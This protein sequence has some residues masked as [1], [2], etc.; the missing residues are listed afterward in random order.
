MSH[1][2]KVKVLVVDDDAAHAEATAESLERAGFSMSTVTSG[3]EGVR[4]IEAEPFDIVV[5]DLVMRDLSGLDLLRKA[6]ARWP[7]IEVIVMTGY[8][9]YETAVEALDGG[10]YDYLDK[11][12]NLQIL[13]AKLKKA[14]EKQ[15]LVRDNLE[16]RRQIDKRFGFQGIVGNTQRMRKVFDVLQQVSP[17]NAT[18]LILGESGT[19]KELVARAIHQ[20]SP[21]RGNHFVPL[22]C[23]ALSESILE[24]EL[25][26]HVK[27][28][29]TGATYDRKG[30]FEYA[31]QGTL[32]LDEIGDMPL[33]IQVKLLRVI[34]YGEIFRVGSNEPIKVDVRLVCAT[35]QSL[36]G[37][38]RD[39]R[40]REDLYFRL[41]VVTVELP[42][43]RERLDDLPLLVDTFIK[44]LSATHKK[45]I[46]RI[47][48][49]AMQL[50]YKYPWPGNVRELR[51]AIESMIV[52]TKDDVLD[53]DD[54]P[55][56]ITTPRATG[57]S[58]PGEAGET[59]VHLETAEKEL[60]RQAL[61]IS[62]GNREKA[63]QLLGI[64]ERTL[65]RKIKRFELG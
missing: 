6:K 4:A 38:I 17:S 63:A 13:R 53:G 41:K 46:S 49:E 27:G 43:L 7:D 55:N 1:P 14:V 19:G 11:P 29:F 61:A 22:N 58:R 16:L 39:G 64:G 3:N 28:A 40:F 26:G 33:P 32:F 5:T 8:P 12:V 9:S 42:P 44:E 30:R 65:Y 60:I 31:H 59:G 51:N 47:T 35:N 18:V 24:S 21:R 48:P 54:V 2:E 52:L 23:A 37:L 25:F 10:A 50:F 56:Y 34:E 57:D 62:Q 15:K 20:N 45:P 36:E